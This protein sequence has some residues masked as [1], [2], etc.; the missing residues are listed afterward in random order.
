MIR[1]RLY[2][3][4]GLVVHTVTGELQ[5]A[6]FRAAVV[7]L[8]DLDP[9]PLLSLWDFSDASVHQYD[10]NRTQTILADLV[11]KVSGRKGGRTA[12]VAP[13]DHTFA[14]GRQYATLAEGFNL[15]FEH[16][17]FRSIEEAYAW[18]GVNVSELDDA[19]SR[20]LGAVRLD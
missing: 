4:Q 14:S 3:T 2:P 7:A 9:P 13:S 12:A 16:E 11:G 10:L 19:A 20:D 5:E 17:V 18:L 6:E 15:P 8:Y 1:R